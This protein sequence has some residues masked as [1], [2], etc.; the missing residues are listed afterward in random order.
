M[1]MLLVEDDAMSREL[2]SLLLEAEG[3]EVLV[4]ESGEAALALLDGVRG[5]QAQPPVAV[6]TDLQLPGVCGAALAEAMR[7]IC[8]SGTILL[9]MSGS[10]A[11]EHT[12]AGYD[13]FLLKPFTMEALAEAIAGRRAA[14]QPPGSA[15]EGCADN[16]LDEAV[17]ASLLRSMPG[18]RLEEL[19]GLCLADARGRIERMRAAA[20]TA[21]DAAFRQGAHAI[22]G[23]CGMVGATELK[24]LAE[25]MEQE[26]LGGNDGA[27]DG[28]L[29]V[30]AILDQFAAACTRLEGMLVTRRTPI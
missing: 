17:Y 27:A 22:K 16:V 3:H 29:A 23:G 13:G 9:A 19:Y 14:L 8:G 4:A 20:A 11:H 28:T 21:D 24:T 12:R 6:L 1:Q 15:C 7:G 26:G 10:D 5:S 30:T 18:A 2:W 25:R